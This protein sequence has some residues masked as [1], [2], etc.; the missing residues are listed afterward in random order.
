MIK[1][2]GCKAFGKRSVRGKKKK[3]IKSLS[4][5]W[6]PGEELYNH[7]HWA[8]EKQVL[9]DCVWLDQRIGSWKRWRWNSS[10]DQP[11][12][13]LILQ[14]VFCSLG[15]E[16]LQKLMAIL[17]CCS[18]VKINTFSWYLWNIGILFG[19]THTCVCVC[20]CVCVYTNT[21][22]LYIYINI[23]HINHIYMT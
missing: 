10:W 16:E 17:F 2:F 8:K 14:A 9:F 13:H 23:Q 4:M 11:T 18:S 15:S 3:Y 21:Q 1:F 12:A 6:I 5:R 19:H 22:V 20:V 7:K